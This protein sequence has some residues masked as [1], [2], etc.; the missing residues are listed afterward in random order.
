MV[1]NLGSL[2]EKKKKKKISFL[3]SVMNAK[4]NRG[5]Y[6]HA[7]LQIN[8]YDDEKCW[9]VFHIAILTV[10]TWESNNSYIYLAEMS[11]IY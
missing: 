6:M 4:M 1:Q 7:V 3:P 2:K 8:T 5:V 11:E 10:G 9:I